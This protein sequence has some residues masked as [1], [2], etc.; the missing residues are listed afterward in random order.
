MVWSSD[1]RTYRT[2]VMKKA[3]RFSPHS[4][5]F[6][7]VC[8]AWILAALSL[9]SSAVLISLAEAALSKCTSML[10]F[11]SKTTAMASNR[12]SSLFKSLKK[13]YEMPA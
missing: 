5:I 12:S 6:M 1:G 4:S 10:Q 11:L 2:T 9:P 8:M 7:A 3:G 13:G